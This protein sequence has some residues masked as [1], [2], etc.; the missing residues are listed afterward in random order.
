MLTSLHN[1]IDTYITAE[2]E[3]GEQERGRVSGLNS[4]ALRQRA[5][6]TP[7][8]RSFPDQLYLVGVVLAYR[9]SLIDTPV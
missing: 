4:A 5:P 7:H 6:P 2:V 8:L 9:S 1:K 3:Q